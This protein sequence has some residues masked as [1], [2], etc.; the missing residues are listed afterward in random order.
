MKIEDYVRVIKINSIS[1]PNE[2]IPPGYWVEGVLVRDVQVGSNI[3]LWRVRNVN[4]PHGRPGVF[5]T[6]KIKSITGNIV[7]TE[8]STYEVVKVEIPEEFKKKL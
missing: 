1:K 5:R 4:Y 6:S 2:E 8:N 7:E 3:K